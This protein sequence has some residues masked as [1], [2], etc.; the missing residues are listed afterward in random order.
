MITDERIDAVCMI[1][2]A[3]TGAKPHVHPSEQLTVPLKG[4][5]RYLPAEPCG[6]YRLNCKNILAAWSVSNTRREK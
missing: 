6:F 5:V 2:P 3:G 1:S 4:S